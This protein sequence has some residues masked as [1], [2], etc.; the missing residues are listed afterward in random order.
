MYSYVDAATSGGPHDT[1]GMGSLSNSESFRIGRRQYS[2]GGFFDGVIDEVRISTAPRSDSWI[3]ASYEVVTGDYLSSTPT[4]AYWQFD[5]DSDANDSS[6]AFDA[7]GNYSLSRQSG[8]GWRSAWYAC[9]P[10]PN[11]DENVFA[12]GS[13]SANT[14]S[15]HRPMFKRDRYDEVFDMQDQPWT[16]EG[17]FRTD[18]ANDTECIAGNRHAASSWNGW[19]LWMNAA[20]QPSFFAINTSS[21]SVFC[22]SPTTGFNDD[23]W[24][25]FAIIWNPDDGEDGKMKIYL[26]G[27]LKNSVTGIGSIGSNTNRRFAVGV[28]NYDGDGLYND[29]RFLGRLDEFRWSNQVL[30]PN[31]FLNAN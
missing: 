24:H 12:E 6:V 17:W 14:N 22:A 19:Q 10:V 18:D 28:R 26:D 4:V 21:E 29:T 25:H 8:S 7:V 11:P 16:L 1:S 27:D 20:G 5:D 31:D 9:D 23:A 3:N 30:D 2:V 15:I 13:P